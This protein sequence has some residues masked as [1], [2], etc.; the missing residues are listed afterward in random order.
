MHIIYRLKFYQLMLKSYTQFKGEL[1]TVFVDNFLLL[2]P[3]DFDD[4]LQLVLEGEVTVFEVA[5]FFVSM[6]N[7]G[8]VASAEELTDT[9]IG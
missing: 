6:D 8:M 4:F 1:S 7:G 5:Y 9:R 2:L 3:Q